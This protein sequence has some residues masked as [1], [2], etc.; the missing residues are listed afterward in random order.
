MIDPGTDPNGEDMEAYCRRRWG[1]SGWTRS[2]ISQGRREGGARFGNWKWWPHTLK[3]HQLV[4]YCSSSGRN[5]C[6]SDRVNQVLFQ[7][8]YE[9]GENISNVDTLV[10]VGQELG[11]REEAAVEDL[12][13]YLSNDMGKDDVKR[14][15][16]VG[17]QRYDISGVP[18][19]IVGSNQNNGRRPQAFS[20]AQG[21]ETFLELFEEYIE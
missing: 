18:F 8:E 1:G 9:R 17:R 15:I 20:G 4:H 13:Q 10:A 16:A 5:I 2:M 12:R 21:S 6:T 19:F 7:F 14:E 11:I 3:A